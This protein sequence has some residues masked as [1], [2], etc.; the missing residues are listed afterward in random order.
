MTAADVNAFAAE[1]GKAVAV[2]KAPADNLFA[3][4]MIFDE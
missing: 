2:A 3:R 4:K 1:H